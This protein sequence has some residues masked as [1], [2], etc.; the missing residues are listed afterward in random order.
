M[1]RKTSTSTSGMLLSISSAVT[2]KVSQLRTF[3]KRLGISSVSFI[4]AML[5]SLL[6]TGQAWSLDQ[7]IMHVE[8]PHIPVIVV[9]EHEDD[10]IAKIMNSYF[11]EKFKWREFQRV[12]RPD[13]F[14]TP[15][16]TKYHEKIQ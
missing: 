6:M 8:D 4:V 13:F 10:W 7:K 11:Q 15:F 5:L 1:S 16:I 12:S 9:K 2:T 14:L 3:R